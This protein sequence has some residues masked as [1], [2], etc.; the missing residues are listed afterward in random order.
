MKILESIL[1]PEASLKISTFLKATSHNVVLLEASPLHSAGWDI[2]FC[3][4]VISVTAKESVRVGRLMVRNG[5]TEEEAR[6][7]VEGQRGKI[8]EGET[9][10]FNEGE[11]ME[12]EVEREGRR[13][14]GIVKKILEDMD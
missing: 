4:E 3:D 6:R 12:E 10:I 11:G 5:L 9:V 1:W 7:R 14:D 8:R 13:I 2:K